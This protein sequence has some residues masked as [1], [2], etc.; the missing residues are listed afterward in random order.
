MNPIVLL[1][2]ISRAADRERKRQWWTGQTRTH[3]QLTDPYGEQT[4]T[5]M[6]TRLHSSHITA[7]TWISLCAS[8]IRWASVPMEEQHCN[9][10]LY[11]VQSC[12]Q[13]M[14]QKNIKCQATDYNVPFKKNKIFIFFKY[15]QMLSSRQEVN[16]Y[17][18][19]WKTQKKIF[20]LKPNL[21]SSSAT[22]NTQKNPQLIFE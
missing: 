16:D 21:F 12:L 5:Q 3:V 18:I 6:H 10:A 8:C 9:T 7:L 17:R 20:I 14:S 15:I 22:E 13:S 4:H 11:S 1:G 2:L 19:F